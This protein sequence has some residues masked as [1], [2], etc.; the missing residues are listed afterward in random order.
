MPSGLNKNSLQSPPLQA[1]PDLHL[2]IERVW[3]ETVGHSPACSG[4][5]L[6][7][8]GGDSLVATRLALQLGSALGIRVPIRT[9]LENPTPVALERALDSLRSAQPSTGD[10]PRPQ[11]SG[12]NLT[13]SFS[14]ERMWFMHAIAP[15]GIA[16]NIAL[17][18]RM[19]GELDVAALSAAVSDVARRHLVLQ[20]NYINLSEG[21]ARVT[22]ANRPVELKRVSLANGRG[23][24]E[25][26][27]Q[28][29][30][31]VSRM[32]SRPFDLA[33]DALLRAELVQVADGDALLVIAIHHIIGDQWSFDI[34]AR[35]L[36]D[37]YNL[38]RAGRDAGPA[39]P[40]FEYSH[41]AAWHR[42]WF[43]RER[44]ERELGYWRDRLSGLEPVTFS[45]DRT[46]PP[47]QSFRGARHRV[48][49]DAE[50]SEDLRR[51]WPR[52]Q[53]PRWRCCCSLRSRCCF[54]VT[55]AARTSVLA[56]RSPTGITRV[57]RAWSAHC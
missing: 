10:G 50:I 3:R 16:Y 46:R 42:E 14:E 49:F 33:R 25:T 32:V 34:L 21:V 7:E 38:I 13:L 39:E 52:P 27:R 6:L 8:Q 24:G 9:V 11:P 5:S 19:R 57:P 48:P 36:A 55:R 35:E 31:H 1:P 47:Q 4:T 15:Q 18:L 20:S 22:H 43:R 12:R 30:D 28:L 29:A 54:I 2:L 53:A 56:C 26:E 41:Y 44:E 40:A 45:P 23:P 51:V 37:R 17:A